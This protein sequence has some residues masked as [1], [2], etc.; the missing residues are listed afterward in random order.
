[1]TRRALSLLLLLP[2]LALVPACAES[3]K[4]A[5]APETPRALSSTAPGAEV[6]AGEK[7]QVTTLERE[8]AD[9]GLDA[10]IAA[11]SEAEGQL[12]RIFAAK[13]KNAVDD[14]GRDE[15]LRKPVGRPGAVSPSPT[16]TMKAGAPES[17]AAACS[18]A[19]AALASMSRAVSRL[20]SLAGEGDR[21]CEDGRA[22]ERSA[23]ARVHASCPSCSG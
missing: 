14:A 22:R 16:A 9:G 6:Q 20:C 19:C 21:R 13:D 2:V 7:K 3:A 18:L 17:P 10:Q 1:M 8:E 4:S 11:L 12:A 15:S 5:S 23:T